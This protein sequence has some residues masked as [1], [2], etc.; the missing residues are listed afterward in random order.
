MFSMVVD[1]GAG[2]LTQVSPLGPTPLWDRPRMYC[3]T[4]EWGGSCNNPLYLRFWGRSR[5]LVL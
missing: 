1:R 2:S 5:A 4:P 3:P